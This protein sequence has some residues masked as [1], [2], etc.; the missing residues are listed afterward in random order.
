MWILTAI[1][2]TYSTTVHVPKIT[3]PLLAEK[4]REREVGP[5]KGDLQ[6]NEGSVRLVQVT[7]SLGDLQEMCSWGVGGR[8]LRELAGKCQWEF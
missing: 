4:E 2:G 8:M 5:C 6:C 7:W 3:V 1:L